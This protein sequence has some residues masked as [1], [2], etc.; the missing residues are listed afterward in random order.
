[1]EDGGNGWCT[2]ESDPGVFT[3]MMT[4]LGVQNTEVAELITLADEATIQSLQPIYGFVFLFKW[5]G[6]KGAVE[7][8]TP[9]D[10]NMCGVYFARQTVH[11]AC[12]TQALI[13]I[14]LNHPEQ[15]ALG[16]TLTEFL[17]FTGDLDGDMRG[18]LIGQHELIRTVHNSFTRSQCFSFEQKNATGKEDV[19]H[20]VAYIHKHGAVW[21]LDGLQ[22]GPIRVAECPDREKWTSVAAEVIQG[23][24]QEIAALDT[25][26]TGQGISFN[27][28]V[29]AEDRLARMRRQAAACEGGAGLML[30]ESIKELEAER[31]KQKQENIRRRHNYMPTIV[32]LLRALQSDG[33]LSGIVEAYKQK[34]QQQQ[35]QQQS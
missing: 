5:T 31:E 29:L 16:D 28:M 22:K 7:R 20:F 21:E 8:P 4:S 13:N 18:D 33:K 19:Y 15:I 10:P 24:M 11:N 14:L 35:Q 23:R 2:I 3:E 26:G 17:S 27:L 25:S 9:S 1:M 6:K 12:A 30:E 34:A 32:A